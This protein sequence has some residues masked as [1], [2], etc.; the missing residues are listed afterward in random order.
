MIEELEVEKGRDMQG[1]E[2]SFWRKAGKLQEREMCGYVRKA[3]E[4]GA[5][6]VICVCV[7]VT[8]PFL[9]GSNQNFS[10]ARSRKSAY[11]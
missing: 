9:R 11:G 2:G 5:C 1:K 8:C 7:C 10:N 3:V 6:D 4:R